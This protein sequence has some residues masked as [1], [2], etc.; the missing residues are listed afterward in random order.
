MERHCEMF[1]ALIPLELLSGN[2]SLPLLTKSSHFLH[3]IP[4][5]L[6]PI[7]QFLPIQASKPRIAICQNYKKAAAVWEKVPGS[8]FA[9]ESNFQIMC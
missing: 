6:C 7:L 8:F 3:T 2:L 9:Y 4:D 1:T 5:N